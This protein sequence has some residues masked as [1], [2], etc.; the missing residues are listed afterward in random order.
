[1]RIGVD[2][3]SVI[4][5]KSGIGSFASSFLK[6]LRESASDHEFFLYQ[7]SAGRDLN[8][9]RRILWES[10]ELPRLAEKD[11]VD[12]FYSPGFSPPPRG[13]F[14]KV[15]TVHDL[16]GLIYPGNVGPAAQWYWSHWLP[17]NVRRADTLVA[18]SESTRRD[19]QK[20][21]HVP[22]REVRVVPLAVSPVF[23]KR[24]KSVSEPTLKKY[25]IS[26]PYF[27][28]VGTLEP[29]KNGV[30]LV[31]AF[32]EIAAA[33][34]EIALVFAG[35]DGGAEEAIRKAVRES[36]LK[37]RVKL[38]GYVP[39]ADLVNLYNGALGYVIISLY[40]GFGLPVLEAMSCGITGVVSRV[41]SLPEVAADTA[42]Q[43]DPADYR[44][45]SRALSEMAENADK[46][47][48]L[49]SAAYERSKNFSYE[50]TAKK[51]IQIF[52]ETMS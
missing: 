42:W 32:S 22:E 52:E 14:K 27:L 1:M 45:V 41:S 43:A 8:M 33:N 40:E 46:R 9:P 49:A 6:A 51:M 47:G 23:E 10:F 3:S 39:D 25:A 38:L 2:A 48:C 13:R 34:P 24:S 4:A 21:L 30:L 17:R 28:C 11:R 26:A 7:P 20:Y 12:L 36:G 31:R 37:N 44:S 35:K 29:R 5:K 15:V 16:I 19:I 50:K 18:S